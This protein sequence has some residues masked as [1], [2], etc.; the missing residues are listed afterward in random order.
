MGIIGMFTTLLMKTAAVSLMMTPVIA[1]TLA[2][3][4]ELARIGVS[5][6]V[7]YRLWVIPA[8]ALV[9]AALCASGAL[10]GY[11]PLHTLQENYGSASSGSISAVSVDNAQAADTVSSNASGVGIDGITSGDP[12]VGRTGKI[13]RLRRTSMSV[14]HFRSQSRCSAQSAPIL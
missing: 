7:R 4:A 3:R 10:A 13:C 8:A 5:A 11:M 6:G 12:A 14:R 1:V 9:I 2:V